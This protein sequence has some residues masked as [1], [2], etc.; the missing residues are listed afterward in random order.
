MVVQHEVRNTE[1]VDLGLIFELFEQSIHYQE[2][3]GYPVWGNYDRNV[4]IKDIENRNQYKIVINSRVAIV[5]SVSYSDKIIWREFDNGDS[6]YLHRI[7]VNPEFQGQKLFGKIL[8]WAVGHCK[9]KGLNTIRMDT[10]AA[11]PTIIEYYMTFGFKI[12]ENYTTPNSTALPVHNR[13]LA[14]TLLE[15]VADGQ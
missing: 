2:K 5:F 8:D 7:V 15:Y 11:N 10:W 4:I 9:E 13:N 14:L 12:I 6:I 1:M 3:K